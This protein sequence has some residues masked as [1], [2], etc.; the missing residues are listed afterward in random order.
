[1]DTLPEHPQI[2]VTIGAGHAFKFASLI[3]RILSELALEGG[4]TYP[5]ESFEI[6]R[7]AITDRTFQKTFHA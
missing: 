1:L 3:G 6:T 4:S 7:P 5:I 2:S